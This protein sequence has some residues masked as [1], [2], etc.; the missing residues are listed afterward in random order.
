MTFSIENGK[1]D[2]TREVKEQIRQCAIEK[3]FVKNEI[4]FSEGDEADNLYIIQS[5]ALSVMIQK[6]TRQETIAILEPG[7]CVGEMSFFN[8]ENIAGYDGCWY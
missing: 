6:F 7:D 2:L 1:S 4:I 5:G 3:P 8:G